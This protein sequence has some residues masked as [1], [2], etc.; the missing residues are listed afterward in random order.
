MWY[1]LKYRGQL[2]R[3]RLYFKTY[4]WLFLK[5]EWVFIELEKFDE[6]CNAWIN[7]FTIELK[8]DKNE[9]FSCGNFPHYVY[10]SREGLFDHIELDSEDDFGHYMRGILTNVVDYLE[11]EKFKANNLK[12]RTN[13]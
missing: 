9:T 13:L 12:K 7:E 5:K 4:K 1:E 6:C 8:N 11:Y 10:F 3:I 2:Y